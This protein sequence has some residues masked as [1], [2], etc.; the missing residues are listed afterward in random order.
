V[1]CY[2]DLTKNRQ[3][4]E[5][6][7]E[8]VETVQLDTSQHYS[9]E[10]LTRARE[11]NP[12]V[13]IVPRVYVHGM[14]GDVFFLASTKDEEWTRI[15]GFIEEIYANP[16]Y[17]GI[18][19]SSP[20]VTP[21]H[22]YPFSMKNFLKD[23]RAIADKH[24]KMLIIGMDGVD[25]KPDQKINKKKARE[26][27]DIADKVVVANYDCPRGNEGL[28]IPIS[29]MDWVKQNYDFYCEVYSK[30]KITPKLIMVLLFL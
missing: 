26:L 18:L 14:Q 29:P 6:T 4:N 7:N 8:T 22:K 19:F 28:N 21:N 1:P 11:A 20:F 2:Y 10:Y 25:P 15:M 13:K 3:T 27:I 9:E 24:G 17:Q 30:S 12:N 5:E 16:H 23:I